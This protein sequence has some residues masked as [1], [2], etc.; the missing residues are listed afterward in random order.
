MPCG[1]ASSVSPSCGGERADWRRPD[2]LD[3]SDHQQRIVDAKINAVIVAQL[4]IIQPRPAAFP[5]KIAADTV[6]LSVKL[7][8]RRAPS[9]A[10]GGD[11]PPLGKLTDVMAG[12]PIEALVNTWR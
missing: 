5:S 8:R 2:V 9:T 3:L 12:Q 4:R 7:A 6:Q 11:G 1:L 10:S